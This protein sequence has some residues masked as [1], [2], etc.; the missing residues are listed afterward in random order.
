MRNV[1]ATLSC[2]VGAAT[3]ASYTSSDHFCGLSQNRG[4]LEL[5]N[6][7]P[8]FN[9]MAA[10]YCDTSFLNLTDVTDPTNFDFD[11]S[12]Y[13]CSPHYEDEGTPVCSHLCVEDGLGC[14]QKKCDDLPRCA[15]FTSLSMLN[16]DPPPLEPS[17]RTVCFFLDVPSAASSCGRSVSGFFPITDDDKVITAQCSTKDDDDDLS[18]WSIVGI[19]LGSVVVVASLSAC[20]FYKV[21][22]KDPSGGA[23]AEGETVQGQGF[24]DGV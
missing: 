4:M 13:G 14:C 20:V 5:F 12:T 7:N 2:L 15:G 6:N 18:D 22:K 9:G 21:C 19:V 8:Y 3:A 11:M 16:S 24:G 10:D 17:H 23:Y 1:A